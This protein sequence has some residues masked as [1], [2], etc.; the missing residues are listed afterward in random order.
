MVAIVSGNGFGLTNTSGG[1]LGQQGLFGGALHGN[2]KEGAYVN[3]FNGNLSLQDGDGFLASS[4]INLALTRTYNSQAALSDTNNNGW[5]DALLKQVKLVGTLNATDSYVQRIDA[6]GSISTFKYQS[7]NVYLSTDGAGGFQTITYAPAVGTTAAQWTWRADRTDLNGPYEVYDTAQAGY[8]VKAGDQSAVRLNYTYTKLATGF[9]LNKVTDAAGDSMVLAY[10]AKGNLGK[11]TVTPTGGTAYSVIYTYD[12]QN[13]LSTVTTDLTPAV[14]SDA[15]FYTTTYTYGPDVNGLPSQLIIGVGQSDGTRLDF[16]YDKG[17]VISYATHTGA[18]DGVGHVTTFSY[19]TDGLTTSVTDPLRNVTTYGYDGAGQL[20]SVSVP[21]VGATTYTYDDPDTDGDGKGNGNG[22]GNVL[23]MTDARGLRTDYTYDGNGRRTGQR[24]SAGNTVTRVYAPGS[25]LLLSETTYLAPS[26][27][28]APTAPQTTRYAYDQF[29]RLRYVVTPEGRVTEYSYPSLT[30]ATQVEHDVVRQYTVDFYTP[31]G[32]A[33]LDT[34]ALDN[35]NGTKTLTQ[36]TYTYVRG[37][38]STAITLNSDGVTAASTTKYTYTPD[39]QLLSITD[40]NGHIT[41]FTYD[42][43]GRQR[44]KVVTNNVGTVVSSASTAYASIGAV[45]TDTLYNPVTNVAFATNTSTY[46]AAGELL[47]VQQ[48]GVVGSTTYA[49][50]AEGHVRMSTSPGG[51]RT[52]WLYDKADRQV[53][54]I[55]ATGVLTELVYNQGGQVIRTI[56]YATAL[57][58]QKIAALTTRDADGSVADA[59]LDS[60]RPLTTTQDRSSWNFYDKSGRLADA[61]DTAGYVTHYDYDGAARLKAT[62]R[63]IKVDTAALGAKTTAELQQMTAVAQTASTEDRVSRKLYDKDGLLVGQIDARGYL[64]EYRYNAAGLL[65]ETISYN[66]RPTEAY[67]ATGALATLRPASHAADLREYRVYDAQKR[68]V[69]TV[70]ADGYLTELGYDVGGN[71]S[72]RTSYAAKTASPAAATLALIKASMAST[73]AT[74]AENRVFSYTYDAL[75]RLLTTTNA[76]NVNGTS[77][78]WITT[79]SYDANGKLLSSTQNMG[80]AAASA[81]YNGQGRLVSESSGPGAKP[82]TYAYDA[83]GLLL[84]K[85]APTGGV[86]LYYYDAAGRLTHTIDPLGYVTRQSYN[87]FG[88]VVSTRRYSIN[89]TTTGLTGGRDANLTNLL[90]ESATD[91]GALFFY[92]AAGRLNYTVAADGAV[93]GR[94]YGQFGQVASTTRYSASVDPANV[95]SGNA[96]WQKSALDLVVNRTG[97]GNSVSTFEYSA[98]GQLLYTV[99]PTGNRQGKTYDAF[100]RVDSVTEYGKNAPDAMVSYAYNKRGQAVDYTDALGNHVNT[101]YNAFGE[102]IR[103]VQRAT[104]GS[105]ANSALDAITRSIYDDNGR[106]AASIDPLGVVT[107]YLYNGDGKVIDKVTYST[108]LKPADLTAIDTQL[109][110]SNNASV[111]IIDTVRGR[112][113]AAPL[114]DTRQQFSYDTRGRLLAS[115][116]AKTGSAETQDWSVTTFA[117]DESDRVVGRTTY[118]TPYRG[119]APGGTT[120]PPN[121]PHRPAM[122]ACAWSMTRPAA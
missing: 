107:F 69:G 30:A 59:A 87:N 17:R 47:S 48:S 118:A 65:V 94:S 57:T 84:S 24:D 100:G 120:P 43:L 18:N 61:V 79:N 112:A 93:E 96:S 111:Q 86:T 19:G 90:T 109:L 75:G 9:Q 83:D 33:P 53:A 103:V 89:L 62:L 67:I 35:W 34:V 50:D 51:Q 22:N 82:T 29:N 16:V 77:T 99:G 13:R 55:D 12:A 98:S 102:A 38:V 28:W 21:G 115:Y 14:A 2:S 4:G 105:V 110:N 42:G 23:S 26:D 60:F 73:T 36:T 101:T 72:K 92:D 41:R 66:S 15:L 8:I 122:R 121:R 6:D 46:D 68:L 97:G 32:T 20:T 5:Q 88:Q 52:Y 37:R 116:T 117:Y 64:T 91:Q 76:F 45:V 104:A 10:D 11:V 39:G 7:P 114:L 31:A 25:G 106:L 49:Y 3:V 56:R 95:L 54:E 80:G 81:V 27:N 85:T 71:V 1:V 63:A 74:S 40:G 58:A 108:P 44:T 113:V 119:L 70:D 78:I